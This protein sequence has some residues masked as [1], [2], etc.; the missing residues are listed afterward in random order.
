MYLIQTAVFICRTGWIR[1]TFCYLVG[2][3]ESVIKCM[4]RLL[5]LVETC[6]K[7]STRPETLN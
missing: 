1:Q 7:K 4:V 2:S 3:L 5:Q 6:E